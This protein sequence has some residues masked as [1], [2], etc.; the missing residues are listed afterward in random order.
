MKKLNKIFRQHTLLC[1]Q[2]KSRTIETKKQIKPQFDS[3]DLIETFLS[4]SKNYLIEKQNQ[5]C[6]HPKK[7]KNQ[8]QRN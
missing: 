3:T 2:P 8:T 1:H 7:I 4:N 5:L 6:F